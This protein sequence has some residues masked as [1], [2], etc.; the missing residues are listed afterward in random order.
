M[1][2][3]F[4]VSKRGRRLVAVVL[5]VRLLNTADY[6]ICIVKIY[7]LIRIIVKV[8]AGR[9]MAAALAFHSDVVPDFRGA[10]QNC[11]FSVM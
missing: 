1:I 6:K 10:R 9:G 2:S 7:K 5:E 3:L 4:L 8:Y 11:L